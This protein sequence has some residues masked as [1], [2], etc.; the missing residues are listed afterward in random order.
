MLER[1]LRHVFSAHQGPSRMKDNIEQSVIFSDLISK[2]LQVNFNQPDSSSDGGVIL[3]KAC[4]QELGL[5]DAVSACI[6]DDRQE[7]KVSHTIKDLI[8]QRV[9]GIACGYEDCNDSARLA[10]DPLQ[11]LLMGR[12]PVTGTLLASQPTLSRFENQV[13][14][15]SLVKMGHAICDG[16]IARHRR[17]LKRKV[18][19]ITI[20]MDPTDDRTYGG[21]QLTFFNT[22]YD[23]W[24]YLPVACFLQF[25]D[26]ADQY[27]FAY[28][29]RPGDVS[30]HYGSISILRR[31]IK[32]LRTAFSGVKIRVRLDGGFCSAEVLEFLDD[33][34][35]EYVVAI[36]KNA[37]L[38]DFAES[39]MAKARHNSAISGET[40][41]Y[42]GECCYGARSW[43]DERRV[44]FKAEVARHPGRL[45]RDNPRFVVTNLKSQPAFVYKR[46]YCQRA[47]IENRIKELLNGLHIDRTSCTRFF[48]NQ[49]RGLLTLSAYVLFQEL[50]LR[51]AGTCLANAQVTTLRERLLKLAVWLKRSTRR[52]VLHLPDSA[53]WRQEWIQ[54]ARALDAHPS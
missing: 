6:R 46:V 1:A 27:A 18:R 14:G 36:A 23:N 45:P 26:E 11:R 7:G 29:L 44:I 22:H 41:H 39:L 16:V 40:E 52:I 17:R 19:R 8:Q 50:R 30:A 48:A 53:P 3:L 12:D 20:D 43:D 51:A 5:I 37:V 4:D 47:P 54:I 35:V 42:F 24:C 13:D 34:K 49:L 2:P 28:V 32:K 9:F 38:K 15:R 31:T 10:T 25:D 21:Q 33:Q